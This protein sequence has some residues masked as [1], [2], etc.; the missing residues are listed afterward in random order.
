[1]IITIDGIDGA[2]K[3]TL[4]KS[5]ANKLGFEYVDKPNLV[6]IDHN[7]WN[8]CITISHNFRNHFKFIKNCISV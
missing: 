3:A 7:N 2:G 5:L 4:A 8:D 6:V 1:M